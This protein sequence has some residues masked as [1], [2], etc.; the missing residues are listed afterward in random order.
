MDFV[1]INLNNGVTVNENKSC[2]VALKRTISKLYFRGPVNTQFYN[3]MRKATHFE[4]IFSVR[5]ICKQF[6]SLSVL[7][8]P[9]NMLL[10]HR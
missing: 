10:R 9:I 8:S 2:T 4:Q 5:Q 3:C 7:L 1:S 6:K